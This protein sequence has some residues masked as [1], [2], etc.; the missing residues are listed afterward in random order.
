MSLFGQIR[1]AAAAVAGQARH[2]RIDDSKLEE[3]AH[4]LKAGAEDSPAIDPA[5][6]RLDTSEATLAF[7]VTLDAVNFGSG[8]FPVLRKPAGLSGY[9]TIAGALRQHFER[10][11]AWSAAELAALRAQDCA[12]VFG[13][14]L[15]NRGAAELMELFARSLADLGRFIEAHCGGSFEALIASAKGS[16][17]R[18]VDRLREMPL[19]RDVSLYRGLEV[20]LYKRA[21][22]TAWDLALA[23][24]GRA[25]GH[26]E[27]LESLTIFADNLVPHVLHCEGVLRYA[28]GLARRIDAAELLPAGSAEE[29]EIRAGAVHAVERMVDLLAETK[30]ST[31]LTASRLDQLLWNRGQR[32]AFKTRNRH[33]TR[34]P[35]PRIAPPGSAMKGNDSQLCCRRRG[36]AATRTARGSPSIGGT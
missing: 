28:P 24:D 9:F 20:P 2:V 3:L 6:L 1:Q 32:P 26:F 23:F 19:Y 29:I 11:G 21:Q 8:W 18:L 7:V 17:E 16:A 30:A 4:R 34:I 27:D 10:K 22:I 31:R 25:P 14:D 15:A 35:S 5:H 36:F 33:R 12:R 13:Q